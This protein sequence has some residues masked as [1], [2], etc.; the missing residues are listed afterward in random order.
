MSHSFDVRG[1]FPIVITDAELRLE[2]QLAVL[3]CEIIKCKTMMHVTAALR[4][5]KLI[6]AK[7]SPRAY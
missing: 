1:K 6:K 7:G 3:N 5:G 4:S 2:R